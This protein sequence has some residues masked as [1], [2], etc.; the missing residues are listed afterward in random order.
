VGQALCPAAGSPSVR[1]NVRFNE[2]ANEFFCNTQI[3]SEDC[4]E[5]WYSGEE[6]LTF[7]SAAKFMASQIAQYEQ[8]QENTDPFSYQRILLRTHEACRQCPQQ[9]SKVFSSSSVLTLMEEKHLRRWMQGAPMRLGLER[10]A[11]RDLGR[12]RYFRRK[13]VV[14]TILHLQNDWIIHNIPITLDEQAICLSL[15]SQ[16]IS[17]PSQLFYRHLAQAQAISFEQ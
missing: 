14:Q 1:K 4:E 11:I 12:D 16:A 5:L 7:K 15:A 2:C 13:N 6:Y 3:C 9:E 8:D 10:Y 17:R